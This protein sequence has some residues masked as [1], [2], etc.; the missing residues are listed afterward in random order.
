MK[1]LSDGDEAAK[2]KA[3]REEKELALR[4]KIEHEIAPKIAVQ[5]LGEALIKGSE[6]LG[7]TQDEMKEMKAKMA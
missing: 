1:Y 7:V 3:A 4:S 5:A 2:E 6:K